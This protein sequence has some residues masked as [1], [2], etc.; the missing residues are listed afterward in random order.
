LDR[1]LVV[2]SLAVTMVACAGTAI[3]APAPTANTTYVDKY[4]G[5]SSALDYATTAW[6]SALTRLA[7]S[8]T[9]SL[10][11]EAPFDITYEKA[12][13]TFR[14][15]L[16]SIQF[17]SPAEADMHGLVNAAGAV[18]G[19]LSAIASGRGSTSQFV[20]DE[21]TLQAAINIVQTDLSLATSTP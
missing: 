2:A 11:A 13:G 9:D 17:P 18:Q 10:S 16:L 21:M 8:G 19:D 12:L 4:L 15:T 3:D 5:A 20:A 1:I 7:N 6:R 14:T